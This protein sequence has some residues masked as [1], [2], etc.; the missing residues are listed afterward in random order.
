VA[1]YKRALVLG[2]GGIVGVAWESGV[3]AG[4][5]ER[6]VDLREVDI[7]VGTSAGAIVGAQ[8]AAGFLPHVPRERSM[9]PPSDGPAVDRASLDLQLLGTIFRLWGTMERSTLEQIA[10]IGK[11]AATMPRE[12]Q[13]GWA[14]RVAYGM[15]LDQWPER[16]LLVNVVDTLSGARRTLDRQCGLD[17]RAVV[18]ASSAV[19][20]MFPPV[21][22]EGGLYM[23][24]QVHSSTNADVL[25]PFAPEQVWIA[26][27]TNRV[28]GQGIGPHAENM[29]ELEV[30]ALRAAGSA[31]SVRMP[32][33]EDSQRLGKNLMDGKRAGEAFAV[34]V[35][36]GRAW[37]DELRS[38]GV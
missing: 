14:E 5:F 11:L 30:A 6:G 12:A 3:A 7:V 1:Q 26:M 10:A 31:V 29:L 24:G 18:T 22:L 25:L 23:D 37:A 13:R 17:V 35:E 27:P 33:P 34:G 21:E 36:A 9:P 20:G 4:L 32:R 38:Q 19:P 16:P 28:T 8:L 15:G 2:G